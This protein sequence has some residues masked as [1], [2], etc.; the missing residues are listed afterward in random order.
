MYNSSFTQCV[1]CFY[2]LNK[3]NVESHIKNK[4]CETNVSYR[5]PR[6]R[7]AN[8]CRATDFHRVICHLRIAYKV[9]ERTVDMSLRCCGPCNDVNI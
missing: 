6:S 3:V 2:V 9:Y 5:E 4:V 7:Y 8:H 1:I